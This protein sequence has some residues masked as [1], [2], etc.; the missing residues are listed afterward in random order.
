M[1]CAALLVTGTFKKKQNKTSR[2]SGRPTV[3]S[4]CWVN[5]YSVLHFLCSHNDGDY[6]IFFNTKMSNFQSHTGLFDG[7]VQDETSG[8]RGHGCG[9]R[10]LF[11]QEQAAGPADVAASHHLQD[12]AHRGAVNHAQGNGVC[13]VGSPCRWVTLGV[14]WG[15]VIWST[16]TRFCPPK[17]D[18]MSTQVTTV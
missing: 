12:A 5:M 1:Y 14:Q 17:I 10:E 8:C 9:R 16:T 4:D 2:M 15:P 7:D 18:H 6:N 13:P 11:R 3:Y